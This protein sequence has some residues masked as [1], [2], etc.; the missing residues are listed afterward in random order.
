MS[1]HDP[2]DDRS[3]LEKYGV[4]MAIVLVLLIG[5]GCGLGFYLFNGKIPRRHHL[6]RRF[7]RHLNRRW[8][9]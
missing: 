4:A 3:F 5:A 8:W 6:R 1:A 7:R 2:Y 9:N